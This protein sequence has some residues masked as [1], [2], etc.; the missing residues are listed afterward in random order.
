MNAKDKAKELVDKYCKIIAGVDSF[1]YFISKTLSEIII[2]CAILACDEIIET[3]KLL[4]ERS[5][6]SEYTEL[7]D[8]T[9]YI[10]WQEVKAE[11]QK[12]K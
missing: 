3:L 11:I 10:Y 4:H 8:L 6:L 7:E 12:L 9:E 2:E 1:N 5:V